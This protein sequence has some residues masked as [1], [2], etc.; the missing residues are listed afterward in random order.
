MIPHPYVAL[1]LMLAIFRLVRLIGWDHMPL[2]IRARSWATGARHTSNGS[3][4]A[5]LGVTNEQVENTVT[6]KRQWLADLIACS[7]CSGL[8]LSTAVYVAW[9]FEPRWTLYAAV[10]LALS[11]VVGAWSRWIDP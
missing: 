8:W 1:I 6:F 7:Y 10:P 9:R 4:N 3:T 11:T 5:R 2:L